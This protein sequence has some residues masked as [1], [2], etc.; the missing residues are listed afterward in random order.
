MQNFILHYNELALK[1]RNRPK[2]EKRLARNVR[3]ALKDLGEVDVQ[4]FHSHFIVEAS[5]EIPEPELCARLSKIFGIA[6][7]APT[8]IVPAKYD[9]IAETALALA[10]GVVTPETTFKVDTR[11]GDKRF[12]MTSVEINAEIGSLIVDATHAPVQLKDPDVTLTIQ[13]YENAAYL[14]IRRIPG[15]GGLP[16]GVSGRLMILLSGGIDSPVAAQMMMKR[17]GS[18][19]FV[20]FHLLPDEEM[21]RKSKVVEMAYAL[22][23]PHRIPAPLFMISAELFEVAIS[24]VETRAATVVFRRFVTRAAERL[25]RR[26]NALALVTGD[27]LGQV[28]SQ[29]LKNM[30]VISK[31]TEMPILRPLVGFDKT[32]IVGAAKELGTYELSIRPYRDPCSMRA[33]NPATWANLEQ[34][35]EVEEQ[36]EVDALLEETL[37]HHVHEIWIEW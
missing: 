26:R 36:I 8:R 19:N 27:N 11:R 1:G 35:L 21:V 15:P 33:S 7:F 3:T 17:G 37:E 25:A 29:T 16:L 14:F 13:I 5:G 2:F 23:D 22:M 9:A 20:H 32:E 10:D 28:A 30:S 6:Y 18:P 12:P 31:A 4:R 34:V 24:T